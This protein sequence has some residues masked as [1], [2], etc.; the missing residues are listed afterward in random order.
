MDYYEIDFLPVGEAKSGDAIALRYR[1][2]DRTTVHVVD[3]GYQTTGEDVVAHL[4]EHYATAHVDHVVATHPDGDHAGGL[5]TVLERCEVGTFWMNRPW[6]Y[7][8]VLLPYVQRF[9]TASGLR[10]RVGVH[11]IP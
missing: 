10:Q 2:D 4:R 7:A 9:T 6:G 11:V 1:V 5:R 3:G 8:E